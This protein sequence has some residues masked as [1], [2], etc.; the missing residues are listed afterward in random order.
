MRGT[1]IK[2]LFML[3]FVYKD[4]SIKGEITFAA[5]LDFVKH[6]GEG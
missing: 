6:F 4:A 1:S 3:Y 5:I 2:T